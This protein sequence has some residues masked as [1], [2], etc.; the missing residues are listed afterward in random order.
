MRLRTKPSVILFPSRSIRSVIVPVTFIGHR[1]NGVPGLMSTNTT[2]RKMHLPDF[3][4]G[5]RL[6]DL[7]ASMSSRIA[8]DSPDRTSKPPRGFRSIFPL[9]NLISSSAHCSCSPSA[10]I[11]ATSSLIFSYRPAGTSPLIPSRKSSSR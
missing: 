10:S 7:L 3:P 8:R 5:C 9:G 2:G 4:A 11:F 1:W 6:M